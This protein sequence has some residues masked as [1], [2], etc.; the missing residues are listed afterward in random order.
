M[1]DKPIL[2]CPGQGAQTVGMGRA[3]FDKSADA[4][5]TFGAADEILGDRL[6]AKLSELCF[7]G[8][9]DQLNRTDVAQPA[10]YVCAI[11][12]FQAEF[13]NLDA[14]GIAATAGL[15]LGEYTALHLAQAITFEDGL[16]LVAIRGRA[17]QDAAE[18][19]DSAMVAL[20]GADEASARELCDDAV[21][22]G[23]DDWVLVP[24]NFNAPGQVVISGSD[25][26][27]DLAVQ[28]AGERGLRATKLAVAGAFHSPLMQ[29]AADRLRDALAGVN[30]VEPRCPVVSNVTALPHQQSAPPGSGEPAD[31]ST[32]E[33]IRHRLVRQLTAPVRW[34]ESCQWI[35]DHVDGSFHELAPG[36][37]LAGL[38]RR[39]DRSAK[40]TTHDAP[41]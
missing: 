4:A 30:I 34:T 28:L 20:I 11:A 2:L 1:S 21:A 18:A 10:L 3:W 26:A 6:G 35:I 39:I 32:P 15:S 36:K 29:P 40:V 17:M 16:N 33:L 9:E 12:S 14:S 22:K 37:V 41:Q 31:A 8:P 25:A 27:C 5:R 7:N 19:A 38:M 13:G 24:A 23:D